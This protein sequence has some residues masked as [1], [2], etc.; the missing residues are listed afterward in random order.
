[1]DTI[2][3]GR[4]S[5]QLPS[6]W[7]D[8]S[9]QDLEALADLS[10]RQLPRMTLLT[11]FVLRLLDLRVTSR[12]PDGTFTLQRLHH[13]ARRDSLTLTAEEMHALAMT[14]S[15]ILERKKE[16]KGW[17]VS[18][19]LIGDPYPR[20]MHSPGAALDRLSYEEFMYALYYQQQLEEDNTK[21]QSLLACIWHRRKAFSPELIDRDARR[22]TRQPWHRQQVM[23]WYWQGCLDFLKNRFPRI[24]QGEAKKGGN[25]FDEQLRVIDALAQGDMTKKDAVRKGRLY[26]ALYSMDEALRRQEEAEASL[27]K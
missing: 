18:S 15:Y 24:F 27:H 1:M 14:Q 12:Q 6:S 4:K 9:T 2:N 8:L 22:I 7:D 19:H 25:I 11:L 5:L 21:L 10:S 3:I 26:D 13:S 17:I 16:G 23:F 20:F